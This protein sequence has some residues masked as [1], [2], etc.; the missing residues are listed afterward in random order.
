MNAEL[1]TRRQIVEANL[2]ASKFDAPT[3]T[4]IMKSL[5]IKQKK[6]LV[7]SCLCGNKS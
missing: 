3:N 1:L 7:P 4:T 5:E 6:P 2:K